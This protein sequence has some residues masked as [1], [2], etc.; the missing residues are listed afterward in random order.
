MDIKKEFL[1]L[2]D[3][4]AQET[5][6]DFKLTHDQIAE[7]MAVRALHL[8]AIVAEPGF[9]QAVTAERNNVAMYVGLAASER[10]AGVD[11]QLLGLISGA[12]RIAAVALA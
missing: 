3:D 6:H 12:I 7:Y 10:A 9:S 2:L 1:A 11:R 5:G 4:A 8:S